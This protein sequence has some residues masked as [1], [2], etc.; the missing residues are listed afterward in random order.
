MAKKIREGI[1]LNIA[2]N[3]QATISSGRYIVQ[4]ITTGRN[5]DPKN[6]DD[7][8]LIYER[9]MKEWFINRAID[10]KQVRNAGFIILMVATSYI[11]GIQQNIEG[12]KSKGTSKESFVESFRTIFKLRKKDNSKIKSFYDQVR[13]GLFHDGMTRDKVILDKYSPYAIDF[14]DP[15]IIKINENKFIDRAKRHFNI[16]LKKIKSPRNPFE[17]KLRQNFDES[18][19]NL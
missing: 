18:F 4:D 19:S 9:Q 15:D 2:P 6:V 17:H 5:L 13:C 16:Y 3:I 12:K 14:S 8:I 11:E 7:K 1:W 10:F